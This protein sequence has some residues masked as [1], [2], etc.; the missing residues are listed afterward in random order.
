MKTL[1][2]IV[3]ALTLTGCTSRS[4]LGTVGDAEFYA[5]TR[6]DP[7]GVNIVQI[8]QLDADGTVTPLSAASSAPLGAAVIGG[9]ADIAAQ[10]VR[11]P[12]QINFNE[13]DK[14]YLT[15]SRP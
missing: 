7:F 10:R 4:H 3:A 6:T 5:L 2:C 8:V 11:R 9:S 1:A 12:D 13:G 15:P 14:Q